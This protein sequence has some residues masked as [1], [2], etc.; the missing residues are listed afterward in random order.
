M[1]KSFF[2]FIILIIIFTTLIFLFSK[3]QYSKHIPKYSLKIANN[4]INLIIVETEQLRTTGLG[5]REFLPDNTAM[6]FTFD[7]PDFYGIWMK[8]MKISIDIFWLDEEG[9]IISLEENVSPNTYPKIFTP[10]GKSSFVLETNAN[11]AKKN[12][13]SVGKVLNLT[14]K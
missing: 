2:K 11:F 10:V 4:E 5:G 3:S 13:L 12:N 14:L 1:L 8:D 6:L 9:R 7:K